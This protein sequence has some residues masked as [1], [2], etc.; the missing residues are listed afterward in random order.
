M[1][2]CKISN[3]LLIFC[4]EIF[5]LKYFHKECFFAFSL[6]EFPLSSMSFIYLLDAKRWFWHAEKNSLCVRRIRHSVLKIGRNLAWIRLC[7]L[8]SI[9]TFIHLHVVFRVNC[10]QRRT[11]S[12][13][14]EWRT[15]GGG[16]NGTPQNE[17]IRGVSRV[18]YIINVSSA[19]D[20]RGKT[21]IVHC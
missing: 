6:L 7:L 15:L 16:S 9:I 19:T 5:W 12:S 13:A 8:R 21:S 4:I 20:C 17:I 18:D 14:E 2:L 1:K 10:V 3:K 11:H